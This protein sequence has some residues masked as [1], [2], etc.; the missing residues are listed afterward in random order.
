MSLL[1]FLDNQLKKEIKSAKD[2]KDLNISCIKNTE[3][4]LFIFAVLW[5]SIFGIVAELFTYKHDGPLV[6]PYYGLSILFF[7]TAHYWLFKITI[8]TEIRGLLCHSFGKIYIGKAVGIHRGLYGRPYMDVEFYDDNNK[9][10]TPGCP[11]EFEQTKSFKKNQKIYVLY[12][13][14]TNFFWILIKPR[15]PLYSIR[16]TKEK[17]LFSHYET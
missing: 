5:F 17:Y 8:G 11:I 14:G 1:W 16:K 2:S 7:L 12:I 10:R 3:R 13:E 9:L 6:S 4:T 15:I